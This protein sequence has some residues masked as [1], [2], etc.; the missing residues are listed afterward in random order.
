M[1]RALLKRSQA[2][3]IQRNVNAYAH[4]YPL[5]SY[6]SVSTTPKPTPPD[7]TQK[8]YQHEG[9]PPPEQSWLTRKLKQ[10]PTAMRV[11]LNVFGA[12]GYGNARQVAARRALA[13]YE[14]LCVVRTEEDR[15]FWV[16]ECHLPPTFQSWFMV[17]NFHVWILTTRLRSL[18]APQGQA[19]I[20]GLIDHF[21]LDIEDRIRQVLQPQSQAQAPASTS[22]TLSSSRSPSPS[23]PPTSSFYSIP[24][25]TDGGDVDASTSTP[26]KKRVRSAPEAL[27]KKQMK[28]FREQWAGLGLALDLALAQE[29]DAVFAAAMW[30]NLLGA[31]GA[32]GLALALAPTS[33]V[34]EF[35]RVLNSGGSGGGANGEGGEGEGEG[36]VAHLV[37]NGEAARKIRDDGSGVHDFG[38]EERDAY[39][40]FPETMLVLTAYARGEVARL[41]EVSDE[42]IMGAGAALGREAEGVEALRFRKIS[43][44]KALLDDLLREESPN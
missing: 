34:P 25:N 38:P 42:K 37:M 16:Q 4:A 21:F 24:S 43:S 1:Q 35:R 2:I 17:T 11:F 19:Y 13:L 26:K 32:Q 36:A 10:S 8:P 3:L 22:S 12:L 5:R 39:V 44:A 31:R 20:Q 18:P 9:A 27:V 28:I 7:P 23:P 30:R 15:E 40:K 6:A 41:A 29:S 33:P 14:Q